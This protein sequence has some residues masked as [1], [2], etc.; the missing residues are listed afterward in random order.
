MVAGGHLYDSQGIDCATIYDPETDSWSAAAPMQGQILNDS[1]NSLWKNGRW[2][3]TAITLQDGSVLVCSGSFAGSPPNPKPN[4]PSTTPTNNTPEIW[5]VAPWKQLVP[6]N[7]ANDQADGGLQLFPRFHLAPDGRVF[8]SGPGGESFFFETSGG[9]NWIQSASRTEGLR[10]YAPSVMYD[11]GKIVFIGGGNDS[12]TH[13]PS[14]IVEKIDLNVSALAW[15]TA[16]PMHFRR[17]QHNATLL[18]D[19][20]VLV[21]G[22]TQ[23]NGGLGTPGFD[24]LTGHQP[25]HE[26]ELWDPINDTWT[27]MAK[28]EIDRCYHSTAILLPDGRVMSG[29]GGEYQP[30]DKLEPNDPNASH[31][32]AQI[33]SPP[34]LFKGSRPQIQNAPNQLTYGQTFQVTTADAADISNS[35]LVRLSSVTHSFNTN[36]RVNFMKPTVG[37]GFISLTAPANANICPPGHYL[38]FLLNNSG[39]P[40]VGKIVKVVGLPATP[41]RFSVAV[42]DELT[43]NQ[44]IINK[45]TRPEVVVGLGSTC[46]YGLA[47]CWGGAYGALKKLSG[48]ETVRPIADAKA[49]VA[50]LYLN[51]DGLPDLAN[52]PRQFAQSAN[53]SYLWRG[54]EVTLKSVIENQAGRLLMPANSSRPAVVLVPLERADKVQ[55]DQDNGVPRSL[56]ANEA[57]AYSDLSAK[58]AAAPAGSV[59]SITGPLKLSSSGYTLE[60]RKFQ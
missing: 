17:R 43:R 2:Y 23:G 9:G 53:G 29:G 4:A 24:D 14:Q 1:A 35:S 46:P 22:G 52:W 10:D 59:W 16:Q 13:S 40:S 26:A 60:V 5:N 56:P 15:Q 31:P 30:T 37:A 42:V 41:A 58:A 25:V 11:A 6:F 47:A 19:G 21:T 51:N 57:S 8:M 39:V 12:D 7:N 20:T 54:V 34:Y 36:Q 44:M 32:D 38:L 3:P 49:S 50:F 48:V 27:I 18:A 45:A 33:F 28:E 55:L